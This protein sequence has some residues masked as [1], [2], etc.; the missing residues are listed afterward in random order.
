M[1]VAKVV[2]FSTTFLLLTCFIVWYVTQ[3]QY[4]YFWDYETYHRFYRELGTHFRKSPGKAL[5]I[6]GS[7]I[8]EHDYNT[9]P[10]LFL[11]PFYF[12][13]GSSRLAYIAAIAVLFAFPAIVLFFRV[14]RELHMKD[15]NEKASDSFVLVYIAIV[16]I[17]LAPQFWAPVLLGYVDV[18]GLNVIFILFILHFRKNLAEQTFWNMIAQGLLLSLLVLL[19]RW[20][21]YW[22]VGFLFAMLVTAYEREAIDKRRLHLR[23]VVLVGGTAI[24]SFFAIATPVATR[25]LT[26]DYRDIYSAYRGSDTLWFHLVNLSHQYGLL[27]LATAVLGLIQM[28]ITDGKKQVAVFLAVQFGVTFLLFTRTQ[29]IDIHHYY[30]VSSILFILAAFFWQELYARLKG[31]LSKGALV[32]VLTVI[33]ILNFIIVFHHQWGNSLDPTN[34][35]FPQLRRYPLQRKDLDQVHHLLLTLK[36]LTHNSDSHV[37][38]LSSSLVLNGSIVRSGCYSFES[39]L[40]ELEPKILDTHDVDKRDGLP[41]HFF[42]A[43][44]VIVSDPVGYHLAPQD[45]RVIG[46]LA[47]QLLTGKQIGQAYEKL[48]FMFSLENGS[49][50]YIYKKNKNFAPAA[51]KHLSDTFVELYSNYREKF[52]LTPETIRTLSDVNAP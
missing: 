47:E 12:I 5:N 23:N 25:M 41:F 52:E 27:F 45:Q 33:C 10:T 32:S 46:I 40:T 28:A 9:L 44:Y 22:V 37:Y 48:P 21:A 31:N 50:V 7:S 15:T 43:Q 30:W 42:T 1:R 24:L 34:V 11:M 35:V 13:F 2:L 19:R 6:V 29:L 18:I 51:L 26:T 17:S 39:S 16:F 8:R 4:I 3:E 20:Y 38:V 36:D 49:N 14:M